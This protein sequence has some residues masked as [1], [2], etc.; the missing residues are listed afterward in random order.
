MRV[1][2]RRLKE[3]EQ[4]VRPAY[5]S[6]MYRLYITN[7]VDELKAVLD[8]VVAL[9]PT[10]KKNKILSFVAGTIAY[11]EQGTVRK[12]LLNSSVYT[13]FVY[14][15]SV[16]KPEHVYTVYFPY[17][18]TWDRIILQD[19]TGERVSWQKLKKLPQDL[20]EQI[21]DNSKRSLLYGL[22]ILDIARVAGG[23]RVNWLN[24]AYDKKDDVDLSELGLATNVD[25]FSV[26]KGGRLVKW[27]TEDRIDEEG[28]LRVPNDVVVIGAAH[29]ANLIATQKL[30]T[31]ELPESLEYITHGAFS[32]IPVD[33]IKLPGSLKS[34]GDAAFQDGCLRSVDLSETVIRKI[35][36]HTFA[37]CRNLEEVVLPDTIEAV[38]GNAF[39]DTEKLQEINLSE[40]LKEI[41]EYAF[42]RSGLRILDVPDSVE[43]IGNYAFSGCDHLKIVILPNHEIQAEC[44]VFHYCEKLKKV[45]NAKY[46]KGDSN[47]SDCPNLT[48]LSNLRISARKLTAGMFTPDELQGVVEL[49]EATVV[50]E[51]NC[52]ALQKTVTSI[53]AHENL[54]AIG[55]SAFSYMEELEVVDLSRCSQLELIGNR[56]FEKCTKLKKVI[57]PE[58]CSKLQLGESVWLDCHSLQEINLPN[59]VRLIPANCFLSCRNL[60]HIRWPNRLRIIG[61]QAFKFSGLEEA[62]L[63]QSLQRINKGAFDGCTELKFVEIPSKVSTVPTQCFIDCVKLEKVVATDE[64]ASFGKKAFYQ[65]ERLTDVEIVSNDPDFDQYEDILY[66]EESFEKTPYKEVL[67]AAGVVLGSKSLD[68]YESRKQRW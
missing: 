34:I 35:P 31:I 11:Y 8:P 59:C 21:V 55:A 66:G 68:L 54:K 19:E 17:E 48:S 60:R 12:I 28:V 22:N 26:T 4:S 6:D 33:S 57:L 67:D 65:C 2:L 30:K 32:R 52:F 63:P 50:V 37:G 1:S 47:F 41:G 24:K 18:L 23:T 43:K 20:L 58:D 64:L 62:R 45:I 7:S 5:D 13:I 46:L 56:A 51:N 14:S 61:D 25:G 38:G 42:Y 3:S 49:P 53:V 39:Y 9:F 16:R 29:K 27:P 10:A 44:K 15:D 36:S 40:G